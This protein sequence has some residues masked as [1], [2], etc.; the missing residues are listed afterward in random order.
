MAANQVEN[1][2]VVEMAVSD[3]SGRTELYLSDEEDAYTPS[4]IRG[5]RNA[6]IDVGLTTLDDFAREHRRPDLIKVDVEGAEV[7][8]IEGARQLLSSADAPRWLIETHSSQLDRE[9]RER[10]LDY[11]YRLQS[12]PA[13]IPQK[14]FPTHLIA[15]KERS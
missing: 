12:L 10:L 6:V 1:C 14:P 7:A 11:G 8:V 13:P 15:S 9:V 4:L 3:R 2:R 5:R